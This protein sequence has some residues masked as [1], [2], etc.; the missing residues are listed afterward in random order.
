MNETR[1]EPITITVKTAA[2]ITG[3]CERTILR[4]IE[5]QELRSTTLGRR[6]LVYYDSLKEFLER[7]REKPKRVNGK[8]A[9]AGSPVTEI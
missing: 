3:V 9:C 4:A 5:T 2:E 1:L 7:G 6:R 8:S